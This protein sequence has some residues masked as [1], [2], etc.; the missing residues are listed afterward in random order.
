MG[1]EIPERNY[2]DMYWDYLD[3]FRIERRKYLDNKLAMQGRRVGNKIFI[4]LIGIIGLISTQYPNFIDPFILFIFII[5]IYTY[6]S[7]IE[8]R[9]YRKLEIE[10]QEEKDKINPWKQNN[11]E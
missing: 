5:I 4:L 2:E 6:D 9:K 10:I 8:Y 11:E 1:V 7:I 3:K